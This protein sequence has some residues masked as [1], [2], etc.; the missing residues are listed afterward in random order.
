[1]AYNE[2]LLQRTAYASVAILGSRTAT[3]NQGLGIYLP[4]GAIVTGVRMSVQAATGSG[5]LTAAS[6]TFNLYVGAS[7]LGTNYALIS[8]I[9]YKQILS[10]QIPTALTV[11][12]AG[13]MQVPAT[14]ELNFQWGVSNNSSF[15]TLNTEVYIDYFY[16]S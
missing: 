12:Q 10:P 3:A 14:G 7:S 13:G 16:A 9:T 1:M 15:D 5:S 8:A 6:G 4:A 11:L 2:L